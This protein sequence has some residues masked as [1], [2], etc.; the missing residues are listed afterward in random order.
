MSK[1]STAN[2]PLGKV[3]RADTG[4]ASFDTLNSGASI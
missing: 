1:K 3:A 2:W 4:K